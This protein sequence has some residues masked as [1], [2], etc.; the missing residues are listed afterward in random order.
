MDTKSPEKNPVDYHADLQYDRLQ[1]IAGVLFGA[2]RGAYGRHEPGKGDDGWS[3][4][5]VR[6]A[7]CRNLLAQ[8]AVNGTWNWFGIVNPSKR[9]IFRI[10]VVPVR[11]CR[12]RFANP[13]ERTLA[14]WN[15]EANQR[16]LAFPE[17]PALSK[18]TWRLVVETGPLG[19]PMK[20]VFA[21]YTSKRSVYCSWD[22]VIPPEMVLSE[23]VPSNVPA[24]VVINE[25]GVGVK[26]TTKEQSTEK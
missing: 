21:G 14:L 13:P 5:C 4:G 18:I 16:S 10:G 1:A 25:P 11:F 8:Q 15:D 12:G 7:R 26:P 17:D 3:L 22:L 24:G 6:F 19:D 9:F 2:A 20:L 23:S